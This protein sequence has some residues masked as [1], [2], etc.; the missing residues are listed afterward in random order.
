MADNKAKKKIALADLGEFGLIDRLTKDIKLKNKQTIK[1][2]GDDAAVLEFK[3]EQL[4]VTNDLLV[5]GT[6]FNLGYTPLKHLGYK[7]VVVNISDVLAMNAIPKQIIVSL[8]VS[9]RF[10][11]EAIDELYKGIHIACDHYGVDL[12]G[13]DTCSSHKGLFLSI[14]AIGS[15]PKEKL[16]YRSGAKEN[17][18]LCVSGDLGAAYMGLQL[19]ERE[20]KLFR[21]DPTIQPDLTG[22]DYILQRQLRPQAR[23]DIINYLQT[24]G[25]KPTSMIDIS[26]GLS[27]EA[28][29]LCMNS[30]VGCEIF[31]DK[32]PIANETAKMAEEFQIDPTVCALNGGEDYELLFS[33]Q[34]ADFEKIKSNVSITEI[35]HFT[36]REK[37]MNLIVNDGKKIPLNAQGWNAFFK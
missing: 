34:P 37:G 18:I 20:N 6:H 23:I 32:I 7:A 26:D 25:I 24:Q 1:G 2:V 9:N 36:K 19:L 4:V 14:S 21:E 5:E 30:N 13:G 35:G 15:V 8:A 10:G 27:S 11:L 33:L 28:I 12:V 29:H 22:N 16:V 31:P 3:D 17:D